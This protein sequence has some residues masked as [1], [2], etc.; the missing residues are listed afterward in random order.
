VNLLPRI[1]AY[2]RDRN[3]PCALIGGDALAVHG[4]SRATLDQDLLAVDAR[5]LDTKTWEGLAE[6]SLDIDIRRG[7]ADDPLRGVVRITGSKAERPLDLVVGRYQWQERAIAR[8]TLVTLDEGVD[9]PV[10]QARDLVL[11][12]LY[13]G[14]PQ[15]AWDIQRLLGASASNAALMAEVEADVSVLPRRC[16]DLW[17]QISHSHL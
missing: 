17:K 4:V 16:V 6:P 9:V 2:L 7:D 8:A 11:L 5:V 15:D 13:A 14:G 12:K 3:V 1:A 10:V